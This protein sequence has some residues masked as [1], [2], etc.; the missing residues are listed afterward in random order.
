MLI[1]K[2]LMC[3]FKILKP[4]TNINNNYIKR[5]ATPPKFKNK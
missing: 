5:P 1:D 3:T 2:D 4:I